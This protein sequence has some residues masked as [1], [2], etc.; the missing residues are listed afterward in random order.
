MATT[1]EVSFKLL[2]AARVSEDRKVTVSAGSK[3]MALIEASTLLE[4]E[5]HTHWELIDIKSITN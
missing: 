2:T 5:G 1:Y 4:R 3:S